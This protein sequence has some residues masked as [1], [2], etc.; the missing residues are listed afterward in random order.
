MTSHF[1]IYY[2]ILYVMNN[3]NSQESNSMLCLHAK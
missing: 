3:L 2:F 1:E